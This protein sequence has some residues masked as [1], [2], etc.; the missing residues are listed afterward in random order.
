MRPRRRVKEQ[1][2]TVYCLYVGLTELLRFMEPH[3]Y[4]CFHSFICLS[5]A[6]AALIRLLSL[7]EPMSVSYSAP[8][9]SAPVVSFR[10]RH[11]RV[12]PGQY[13]LLVRLQSLYCF[14]FWFWFWSLLL[15]GFP[16]MCATILSCSVPFRCYLLVCDPVCWPSVLLLPGG[17]SVQISFMGLRRDLAELHRK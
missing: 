15:P 12:W 5:V 3:T 10:C 16:S 17:F 7:H 9:P 14:R 1:T 13:R 8:G 6:I 4:R 2:L 11:A